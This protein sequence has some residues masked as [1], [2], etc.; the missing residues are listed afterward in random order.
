V[1]NN[2]LLLVYTLVYVLL[3]FICLLCFI[4]CDALFCFA[5][6]IIKRHPLLHCVFVHFGGRAIFWVNFKYKQCFTE[7]TYCTFNPQTVF[8]YNPVIVDKCGHR[9]LRCDLNFYLL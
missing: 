3:S 2:Q 6:A 4:F 9:G 1:T 5:L 8:T 7:I